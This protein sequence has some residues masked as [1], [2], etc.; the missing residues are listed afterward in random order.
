MSEDYY[1]LLGVDPD[2]SEAAILRA[3]RE[4][5]A[6]HHP[7]VSDASDADDTFQRLNEAKDVLTDAERRREY[8]R[9]G[10][11]RFV[12]GERSREPSRSSPATTPAEVDARQSGRPADLGALVR[13]LF[14]GHGF[15]QPAGR[16]GSWRDQQAPRGGPSAVDLRTLLGDTPSSGRGGR[17]GAEGDTAAAAAGEERRPC[18]KC[19]GRGRFVHDI[20]TARGRTRRIEPCERCGGSGAVPE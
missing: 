4:Q 15:G 9:V 7:D 20:D 19:R 13:R 10:H 17:P 8:D 1:A 6:E 5:A 16:G 18:P 11:E 14:G 3:Y 12:E 2:A